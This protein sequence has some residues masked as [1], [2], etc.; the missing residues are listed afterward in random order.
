MK[1]KLLLTALII[2]TATGWFVA[3]RHRLE[4]KVALAAAQS[5]QARLGTDLLA[6]RSA[7]AKAS[8]A[9]ENGE[10]DNTTLRQAIEKTH[11]AEIAELRSAP[12]PLTHDAVKQRFNHARELAKSGD[13]DGALKEYL[14]CFDEGMV[15]I[16]AF[17]G[18]RGSYV[19]EEIAKLGPKGIAALRD[20]Y[21]AARQA[22]LTGDRQAI[23]DFSTLSRALGE[24]GALVE[25]FDEVSA[26]DPRRKQVAIYAFRELV[27]KQR[28]TDAML[29]V[30]Y[31]VM[32]G[33]FEGASGR[34]DARMREYAISTA[35]TNIEALAGSGDVEHARQLAERVLSADGS[36]KTRE[37][38]EGH[39]KRAG[40]PELMPAAAPSASGL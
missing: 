32:V 20:R 19:T 37:L 28:Y 16:P 21:A 38:I 7:L 11:L 15:K 26:D 13:V 8:E 30:G 18:V 5:E 3:E 34:G 1:L 14:W 31:G 33:Q 23:A 27:E 22:V 39:L 29:G 12:A 17:A 25:L 40:H 24:K 36:A 9:A 35:A 6:A 4:M 2:G 10:R